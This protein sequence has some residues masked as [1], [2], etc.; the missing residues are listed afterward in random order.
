MVSS[1]LLCQLL[2]T[3]HLWLLTISERVGH[4]DVLS[5]RAVGIPVA[6]QQRA[7]VVVVPR[8]RSD[9]GSVPPDGDFSAWSPN[10]LAG[11][12]QNFGV[13]DVSLRDSL[14]PPLL[15]DVECAAANSHLD[16][17]D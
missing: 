11:G 13:D 3:G 1:V 12:E 6:Q 16:R 10:R 7:L 15:H 14:A 2:G 8:V 9:D 5:R 17:V 4:I